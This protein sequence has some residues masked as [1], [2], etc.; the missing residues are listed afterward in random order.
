[1]MYEKNKALKDIEEIN[2]N[3]TKSLSLVNTSNRGFTSQNILSQL[4]NLSEAILVFCY[5]EHTEQNFATERKSIKASQEYLVSIDKYNDIYKLHNWLQEIASHYTK[6]EVDSQ[7]LM[8][9]Y[10]EIL[11]RIKQFMYNEFSIEIL[12]NISKFPIDIDPKYEEY[13]KKILLR[14][15]E[16]RVMPY[17]RVLPNRYYILEKKSIILGEK[18]MYEMVLTLANDRISK[19]DRMIAFTTLDIMP[20]YACELKIVKTKI[21]VFGKEMPISII[22]DSRCSIRPCEFKNLGKV[23]GYEFNLTRQHTEY[24]KLM[25]Y[26]TEYKINLL[27]LI[28]LNS[29]QYKIITDEMTKNVETKHIIH[30][31]NKCRDIIITKRDGTN[32]LRYFLYRMNNKVI[33]NQLQCIPNSNISNLYLTNSALPFDN[34]P[35][36]FSLK[37]HNAR[38]DDLLYSIPLENRES[39]FLARNIIINTEKEHKIY[40]D[41]SEINFVN[42]IDKCIEEYNSK[43]WYGHK[44]SGIRKY[45]KYLY[46]EDYEKQCDS[47]IERLI[48]LSNSQS[49]LSSKDNLET[50]IANNE[51]DDIEKINVLKKFSMN[52]E[53]I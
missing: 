40:T 20:N 41:I 33:K 24:R 49:S 51:I 7:S 4:R 10:C 48:N 6:N 44:R 50:W 35:F 53:F 22:V 12:Q 42:D 43:L 14:I 1:M 52:L 46:I 39:D 17:D 27:D 15:N 45:R 30:V 23:F 11:I 9:K 3:I 5:N 8:I 13:Y 31:L 36:T 21:E 34:L 47:I 26:L 16:I 37:R 32:I 28:L 18:I 25:Q 38:L 2:K 29:G 19:L